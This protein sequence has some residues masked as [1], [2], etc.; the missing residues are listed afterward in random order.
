MSEP[1]AEIQHLNALLNENENSENTE[2]QQYLT[3]TL[4]NEDYAVDILNV[5]EI[6]SWVKVTQIPNT[7]NYLR[8]V[9]NLRGT[10]IP[11]VDLRLKLGMPFKTYQ[12]TTVVIVI[13]VFDVER[14]SPRKMGIVVD[15]VSDAYDIEVTKIKPAP[16]FGDKLDVT[17]ISGL[18]TVENK[19]IM[20]LDT[21]V[22]LNTEAL[23]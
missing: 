11:I 4:G 3:F 18:A 10:I 7:P 5:Q 20:I 19:M 2:M 22:L 12:P 17:A 14:S 13:K 21:D 8:G 9:L 6:K 23:A 16:D 15:A 1:T